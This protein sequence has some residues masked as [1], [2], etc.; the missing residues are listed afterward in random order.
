M[1]TPTICYK[2]VRKTD[3]DCIKLSCFDSGKVVEY[4]VDRITRRPYRCGQLAVFDSIESIKNFCYLS[5]PEDK[6]VWLCEAAISIDKRAGLYF[7]TSNVGRIYKM[8]PPAGTLLA[9]N[10]K[11]IRELTMEEYDGLK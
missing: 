6:E 5:L 3:C 1:K 2:V 4:R 8:L 10:V 9:N 7:I 11:L